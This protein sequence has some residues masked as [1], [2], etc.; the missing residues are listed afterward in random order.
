MKSCIQ[1]II[2][3]CQFTQLDEQ[4]LITFTF[5]KKLFSTNIQVQR[6]A[7]TGF[8]LELNFFYEKEDHLVVNAEIII[9]FAIIIEQGMNPPCFKWKHVYPE[10]WPCTGAQPNYA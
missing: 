10:I 4:H 3:R 6:K 1:P 7:R 5:T 8:S 9:L 2:K